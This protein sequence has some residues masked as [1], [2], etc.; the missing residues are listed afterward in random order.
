[1]T[2][3]NTK[4]N[5]SPVVQNMDST[6]QKINHYPVDKYL[7]NPF[8]YPLD[9]VIHLLNNQVLSVKGKPLSQCPPTPPTLIHNQLPRK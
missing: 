6:I 7:E 5:K 4:N 2:F 3:I 8:C 9:S 1:M